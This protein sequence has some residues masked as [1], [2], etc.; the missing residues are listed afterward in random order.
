MQDLPP[1]FQLDNGPAA[2][3]PTRAPGVIY[4]AP[5]A[6][7]PVEQ[8]RLAFEAE[9]LRIAQEKL[10]QD[11]Q[12]KAPQGYRY[13]AD[14][15]LEVI[16]GGPAERGIQ[17]NA[18]PESA[19]KSAE[20]YVSQFATLANSLDT[21]TD[22]FAGNTITGGLEN[23]IQ[24][25]F[26]G[27]G[28][29]GQS[30]WWAT[31]KGLDNQIRND[32]FGS[33]L[34]PTEKAAY[35]QTTI[36]PNMDPKIVRENLRTRLG[37]I[38]GALERRRDF[39]LKN[40][41]KAEAVDALFAPLLD[42]KVGEQV[43]T[44]RQ[45]DQSAPPVF[46]ASGF[47][48]SGGTGGGDPNGAPAVPPRR[49]AD[50]RLGAGLSNGND[51][52][53]AGIATGEARREDNPALAGVRD[54][55][56]RRLAA[57]QTAQEIINWAQSA[58]ISR[59][60]FPSIV[61]QV[62]FRDENPNVPIEQYDTTQLDDRFVPL[63]SAERAAGE[64]AQTAP[65][66][67]AAGAADALTGFTLPEIIG[68][69]GG[70]AERA[71]LALGAVRQQSPVA[72]TLGTIGGGVAAT[73]GIEAGLARAGIQ[74]GVGRALAADVAYGTAAGAG[75]AE[76]G[77][78]VQG[79]LTGGT[80][81][82]IGSAGGQAIG[83]GLKNVARGSTNPNINALR[84]AGVTDLT[85]GQ[86]AGQGGR[87][88][89]FVKGVEDRLSGLPVVGDLV[90]AR[91]TEGLRQFNEAAFTKALEPIGGRV[92]G[93]V[94]Q[95]AIAD[96]QE[97]VGQAYRSALA[98][99]GA[100][101][102]EA[103]VRDLT[104]SVQGVK[105]VPRLGD[106]VSDSIADIMRPYGDEV[107]LSGE[108]L[109]DIS[110]SLRD[111]KASYKSDPLGNRIGK[112]IDRVERAVFD[113]FDR[114]ASGTIPEYMAARAAYRRLSVLEDAV[115]K[116]QNQSDQVF[117]PA[118]LGRAAQ[119]NTRK[120]GGKRAAARGDMPFN[121]LQRAGQEVLP[122]RV[123][124]SGT[125]G[126]LLVPLAGATAIGGGAAADQYGGTGGAGI[127]LGA[128]LAGAYTRTGQRILTKPARGLAQNNRLRNALE[129]QRTTRALGALGALTLP[130]Q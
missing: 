72:S 69:A 23:T 34:T 63:S 84:E 50:L 104:A 111:L 60:A 80:L 127:T 100:Q 71:D 30:Q 47:D 106:E 37:I 8:Q 120:F 58:G 65:G 92:T 19:A 11:N 90:N 9:R 54:E 45:N 18:V 22:E 7:D 119:S 81:S 122:N 91:R 52:Y 76:D 99:K 39:L 95:D 112:Q 126:R 82:A 85:L 83:A 96:A 27:F 64:A 55:Y 41:Y 121:D 88:G 78:R 42:R 46:G 28:T 33:A 125:S 70:N 38:Q 32:L 24:Q 77:N 59:S 129:S 4:G 53:G 36:E 17:G 35:A 87:V 31:F 115:L 73:L 26:S 48:N 49:E 94:G 105:S 1:G 15:N 44:Q 25:R 14:G 62:K 113:L 5:K 51:L 13:T 21:F 86:V 56:S 68:A 110:R 97:Q 128:I 66:A 123:P 102:D 114:Q 29:P 74:Q 124:D 40:G 16:P 2:P 107:L 116:A 130:N 67:F 6:P 93:K 79:A 57:G 61:Q 98:G 109:D 75:S 117:T 12:V 3:A 118:Q 103:F 108:A 10:N 43:D 89:Q 20:T 101:P